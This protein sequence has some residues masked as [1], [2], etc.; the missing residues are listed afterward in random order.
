M[1]KSKMFGSQ[2]GPSAGDIKRQAEKEYRAAR[3][4]EARAQRIAGTFD[5]KEFSKT[6]ES[7][8]GRSAA[9]V[10]EAVQAAQSRR[11]G[12]L[13][14]VIRKNRSNTKGAGAQKSAAAI[15][16]L[17]DR[18][19]RAALREQLEG[20]S[21]KQLLEMQEAALNDDLDNIEFEDLGNV[22]D[23]DNEDDWALIY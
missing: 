18:K 10:R 1:A 19:Q 7:T 15:F 21:E 23:P 22:F 2:R 9:E 3:R 4:A 12:T 5:K 20:D 6:R 17:T 14:D 8:I 16:D 11:E 13:K